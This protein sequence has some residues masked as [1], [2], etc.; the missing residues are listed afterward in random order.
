MNSFCRTT[1]ICLLIL[2]GTSSEMVR[3]QEDPLEI[4]RRSISARATVSYSG[5]RTVVVFDQGRKMHGVQQRVYAQ[6][7]D[8]LRIEFIE[9]ASERGKLNVING[10]VRWDYEP[11]TGRAV[12]T[13]STSPR[14]NVNRRLEA[15]D[16]L[17]GRM[18]VQY[19]GRDTVA[20]RQAHVIKVFTPEGATARKAWIDTAFFVNLKTQRFDTAEN[21]RSSVYFTQISFDPGFPPGLFDFEPPPGSVVVEAARPSQQ[22]SL[23][24]AQQEAGFPA[25]LPGYLPPGYSLL[26]ERV[27]VVEIRGRTALWIPFS[28]GVET[29]SLF[30]RRAGGPSDIDQRGGAVT[31][32]AGDFCFSLIGP[33]ARD[34]MAKVRASIRP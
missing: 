34:E 24:R 14:E 27:S 2:M 17:T 12:R 11:G 5:I 18:T 10:A 33:L 23:S 20:G 26:G 13:V 15:L 1:A 19:S 30:Q 3:A 6:A 16:G 21:V 25:V 31:W 22:M 7:P 29:F 32:T 8:R 4:L 9:P 28:N